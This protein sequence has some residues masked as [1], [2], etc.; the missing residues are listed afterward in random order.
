MILL[1]ISLRNINMTKPLGKTS[2]SLK[3]VRSLCNEIMQVGYK[4]MHDYN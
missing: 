1:I 3:P 2:F 4:E